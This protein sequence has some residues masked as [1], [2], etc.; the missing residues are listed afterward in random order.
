MHTEWASQKKRLDDNVHYYEQMMQD[1]TS[2]LLA[3]N[4]KYKTVPALQHLLPIVVVAQVLNLK[5]NVKT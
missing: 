1:Y 2:Q 3:I 4:D 5:M